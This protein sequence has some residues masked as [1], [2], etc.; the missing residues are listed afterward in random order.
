MNQNNKKYKNAIL[1]L[2]GFLGD[3]ALVYFVTFIVTSGLLITFG[4]QIQIIIID[5]EDIDYVR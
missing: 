1:N 3:L 5:R 2:F 4:K